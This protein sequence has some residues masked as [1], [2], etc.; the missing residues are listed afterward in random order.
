MAGNGTPLAELNRLRW[1]CRRGMLE[2]DLLLEGFL[3]EGYAR[4]DE[5]GCRLF[6]RLLDYPDPVLIDWFM[7]ASVPSDGAMRA[8]VGRIR[9]DG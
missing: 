2:L 9:A 3:D 5:D 7:G 1:H 8:L 6:A 4:L